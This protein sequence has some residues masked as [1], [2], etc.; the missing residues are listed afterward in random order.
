MSSA[1]NRLF[2]LLA[3]GY[4]V[5]CLYLFRDVQVTGDGAA[6]SL[7]ALEGSPWLRS[8]HAGALAPLWAWVQWTGLPAGIAGALWTGLGLVSSYMLGL[9]LLEGRPRD[10][11][12]SP[13][14]IGPP[15]LA[16]LGPLSLLA[17]TVT[18]DN[19]LF[20][21]IY[22][23]LSALTLSGVTAALHHRRWLAATC[24][25]WAGLVHPGAWALVPGLLLFAEERSL[26]SWSAPLTSAVLLYALALLCLYPDW[27][28]GGRG[29]ADLPP[30]DQALWPALQ[31]LWRLLSDDLGPASLPALLALPLLSRR[32]L[33]GF[34]LVVIASAG[35]LCRYSDNPGGL[36]ALWVLLSC[37]PLVGRALDDLSSARLRAAWG[38][39]IVLLL[40]F[41]IGDA[42]SA[43][44]ARARAAEARDRAW[45]M[46]G[47]EHPS[48]AETSWAERQL[49]HLACRSE[50]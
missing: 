16:L 29:L 38:L 26:R 20:V 50:F 25:L 49:R 42:T 18:W 31:S 10:Q 30:S 34:A 40:I 48:A 12:L 27:W 11:R 23:P 24:F 4:L 43:H 3:A 5:L 39:L 22:A 28:N 33:M 17:S 36:P 21:E 1:L 41:G 32:R 44:D 8:I 19:A 14:A 46:A 6:Y 15:T 47:C 13:S 9:R 37:A 35:L 7:Q 2:L 45:V